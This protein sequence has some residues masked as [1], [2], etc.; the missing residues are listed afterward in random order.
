MTTPPSNPH[1]AYFRQVLSRVANAESE[2]RS[3]LPTAITARIDWAT[4]ALQPGTFVSE[5]LRS[6]Y[7]DLLYR[8]RI[9][10]RDAYIYLLIEHQSS[11]D[12]C[13]SWNRTCTRPP[14]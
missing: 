12:R 6:S 5:E 8:A 3:A 14:T 4:V 1:D 7:S 11:S 13:G 10:G 9:A 2:L